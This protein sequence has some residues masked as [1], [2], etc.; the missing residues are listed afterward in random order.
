MA[1]KSWEEDRIR[2]RSAL[3]HIRK[4]KGQLT[5]QELSNLLGKPQ[6]YVSKY[7]NGERKLDYI[8]VLGIC[9]ALKVSVSEFNTIFESLKN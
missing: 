2:L 3:K 1:N 7:E 5:Q 8:E 6:S 9:R 4:E